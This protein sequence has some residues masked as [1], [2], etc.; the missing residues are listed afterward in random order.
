MEHF[1]YSV[2]VQWKES[3]TK[4]DDRMTLVEKEV[5][6]KGKKEEIMS[7]DVVYDT[8]TRLL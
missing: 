3:V 8:F 2:F 7:V 4:R 1:F 6:P 5:A